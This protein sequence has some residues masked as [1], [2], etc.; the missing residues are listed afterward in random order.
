MSGRKLQLLF[1]TSELYPVV[2]TGGLADV[3]YSLPLALSA[4][5]VD[6]TILIPAYPAALKSLQNTE[7]VYTFR[8]DDGCAVSE[9]SSL[10]K[11]QIPGSSQKLLLFDSPPLYQRD[12]GIYVDAN[13]NDWPDN[14]RRFAEFCRAACSVA[15]GQCELDWQPDM[16][17]CNDWQSGL[18]PALL[19]NHCA[20]DQ[21]C[22]ASLFTIH[23]L[24]YQGIFDRR[25]FDELRL[26]SHWWS[27]DALEFYGN[28]SF[29]K[30]GLVFADKIT[31]VSPNYRE[32]ILTAE[33]GYGMEGVLDSRRDEL[34]GIINGID[35]TTWNPANDPYIEQAYD[36]DSL[37]NKSANKLSLQ[38]LTGL[39]QD[40]DIPVIGL[41]GR[42]VLQKG[43]DLV[44]AAL[45]SLISEP[46]QWIIL[47]NGDTDFE[48]QLSRLSERFRDK[49]YFCA[50][51]D[52][53]LAHKIEA[54]ADLFIMPSR[55]EPCGLNQL[56]SLRYGTLP[57]V[58]NTG[59]LADTVVD[60]TEQNIK[61]GRA[62]GFV[63]DAIDETE[64][65]ET[66]LHSL[67]LYRNKP[68]WR[69]LCIQAM[70]QDFSWRRSAIQYKRLYD[71]VCASNNPPPP[72]G[73]LRENYS[74]S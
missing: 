42:L 41:V 28:F 66:V 48:E 60:A 26:P 22:P 15:L 8:G 1:V 56:Y 43:I 14:A 39:S 69:Q 2:K 6:S 46:I 16:V 45:K 49:V 5:G 57:I 27:P 13:H 10:L 9:G 4:L 68:L 44:I 18:I 19:K 3:S 53:A 36:H 35:Y 29:L 12:G 7:K 52:E 47:G 64:L 67:E 34:I 11:A 21:R 23:N 71:E 37:A 59:G 50:E 72:C 58:R 30:A 74:L 24:A 32:E 20:I 65:R 61:Q 73:K 40:R 62:T 25:S 33:F 70:R 55:F 54:G 17:H 63:F 38:K 31:T 51:F